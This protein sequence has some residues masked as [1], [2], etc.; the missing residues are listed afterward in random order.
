M[1]S[2]ANIRLLIVD[3]IADNRYILNRRL[4]KLGFEIVEATNGVAAVRLVDQQDFDLVLLDIMMP[5]IDGIEVLK[6]IR[7][8]HSPDKL[9]VIMVT[10]KT[11]SADI[12]E[13]LE[14]GANDYLTK[15]LDF[16]I[17]LARVQSHLARKETRQA[18]ERSI[19]ELVQ[20]NRRLESELA[21]LK[22]INAH[23][24]TPTA[25]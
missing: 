2:A 19:R 8:K 23:S 4:S 10:A 22:R 24:D 3:D 6:T 7:T 5:G 9:P 12:V 16:P 11:S 21:E 1:V 13:A 18:L 17:A 20:T 15:P 14:L 25:P